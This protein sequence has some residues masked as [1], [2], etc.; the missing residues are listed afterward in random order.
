MLL[1]KTL[2][3]FDAG[4]GDLCFW[5]LVRVLFDF[6]MGADLISLDVLPAVGEVGEFSSES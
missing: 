6:A 2:F 5:P 3:L 4:G 1:S